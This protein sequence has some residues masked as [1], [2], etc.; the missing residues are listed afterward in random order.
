MKKIEAIIQP[1]KLDEVKEALGRLGV[2][3]LTA[4]DVKGFGRQKGHQEV[5]IGNVT[6]EIGFIP[7]VKI[8][9]VVD[10]AIADQVEQVIVETARTGRIGDGKVFTF[11]CESAIRIRTS[12]SGNEAL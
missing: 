4:Y 2:Q 9:L 1:M 8:E 3:G 11:D 5:H 7:K 12:E 6:H 10:K